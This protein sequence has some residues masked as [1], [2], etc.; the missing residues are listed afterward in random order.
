MCIHSLQYLLY[1][2]VIF[3]DFIFV[4]I[5]NQLIKQVSGQNIELYP[6]YQQKLTIT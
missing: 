5:G 4:C 2:S 1:I 3:W 6:I